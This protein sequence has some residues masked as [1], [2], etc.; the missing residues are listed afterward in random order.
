M[1]NMQ[2][3]LGNFVRKFTLKQRKIVPRNH[4]RPAKLSES[5]GCRSSESNFNFPLYLHNIKQIL[6]FSICEEL[7]RAE[8]L[9]KPLLLMQSPLERRPLPGRKKAVDTLFSDDMRRTFLGTWKRHDNMIHS[10]RRRCS[11][12][13]KFALSE[14]YFPCSSGKHGTL[15]M[16]CSEKEWILA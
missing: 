10:C 5:F 2:M 15:V 6:R 12:N 9:S 11:W 14:N 3:S 16:S 13:Q 1:R 7:P 4:L 8:T